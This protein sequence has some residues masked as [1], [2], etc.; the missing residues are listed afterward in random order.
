MRVVQTAVTGAPCSTKGTTSATARRAM[1][2]H[3]QARTRRINHK[4]GARVATRAGPQQTDRPRPDDESSTSRSAAQRALSAVAA[5]SVALSSLLA[6]PGVGVAT[7]LAK[8]FRLTSEESSIVGLFK[9]NTPSVVYITNLAVRRDQFT[10]DIQR[11]PQGTGSGFIWDEEGHVVTNFHVIRGAQN[12]QVTLSDQSVYDAS[13]VG[14]DPDRDLAVLKV[15]APKGML[16]PVKVAKTGELQVGQSVYAI[17]NP[18]GLDHTLTMGII[19]G[20]GREINSSIS[21]RPI[22]NMIQ[23]DAAINPG[24]SGG[25]LLNSAGGLIGMNTAIFSSSGT[26]SGVGFAISADTI[27]GAVEQIIQVGRVTRPIIGISF[28]PDMAVEGLGVSGVLVLEAAPNGPASKAGINPTKRDEYGRL[29]LGDIIVGIDKTTIKNS[30]DLFKFL[31]KCSVGQTIEIDLLQGNGKR[32]V[33]VT[34]QDA[35]PQPGLTN[36]IRFGPTP[37]GSQQGDEYEFMLPPGVPLPPY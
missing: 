6:W 14:M 4:A 31:D 33:S 3:T 34:L 7:E 18:F 13:V 29:V 35:G 27:V 8:P 12:L 20:L 36:P 28:A 22:Q 9:A 30:S 15:D 16:K 26:S 10:L 19:S 32:T 25:P 24:N 1:V 23:T 37:D 2:S 21:G 5:T 11:V 17:G